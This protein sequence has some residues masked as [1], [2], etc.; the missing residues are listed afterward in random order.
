MKRILTIFLLLGIWL[1]GYTQVEI[2]NDAFDNDNDGLIDLN[3]PDC[4][5][6]ET[7]PSGLIPNPSFEGMLCCPTFEAQ[8][9]CSEDWI[10]AS[11]ATSD[12]F[13]TC[14]TFTYPNWLPTTYQT[15]T[16]LPDGEGW[17]GFRDGNTNR[18]NYKEYVGAKL[19]A[20]MEVG[21]VYKLDFY[22]GFTNNTD[23]RGID[24]TFYG[25][26]SED[27]LPFG[28]GNT[29]IGCPLNTPGWVQIEQQYFEGLNEWI[30]VQVEFEPTQPFNT[31]V[32]GPGCEIH[33]DWVNQPYYFVDRLAL[34]EINEFD[35][36]FE[37]I[38]GNNCDPLI[39]LKAP[40][41][42]IVQYT[43]QWYK[44][45][46]ALVGEEDETLE[47]EVNE[48]AEGTYVVV[49]GVGSSCFYSEDY[50]LELT[51]R[52]TFLKEEICQGEVFEIAGQQLTESVST[53]FTFFSSVGCDS[54]VYVDLTVHEPQ[55][56]DIH[57]TI[58]QGDIYEIEGDILTQ[59][60]VYTYI[61]ES[62]AGCDSTIFVSLTVNESS[63]IVISPNICQGESYVI[64]GNQ[65]TTT[66]TYFY[67][68]LKKNG[69]DSTVT[70][71]LT[72]Y[73]VYQNNITIDICEGEF[74][75]IQNDQLSETGVY[76]Y[77]MSSID[78]CDSLV[79]IDLVV[80]ASSS[81]IDED[82]I[83]AGE[84]FHYLDQE[85]SSAGVYEV[86]TENSV[87]CD[88]VILL[89]LD[90][91][92]QSGSIT[93]PEDINISLGDSVIISPTFVSSELINLEWFVDS[94]VPVRQEGNT[95]I[96]TPVVSTE[97]TLSGEDQYGCSDEDMINIRV[98]RDIGI[99]APN[100]FSPNG[101]SNND[102]WK[103]VANKAISK[104][105]SL[106]VYDRWGNKVYS[107]TDLENPNE[108]AGWDGMI[109]GNPAS[110]GV[111][112]FH[113]V[114]LAKDGKEELKTGDI[115]L[116]R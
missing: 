44:D 91:I 63:D 16:P 5:C 17:V 87:G 75:Q 52:E 57:E 112:V 104:L 113:V 21:K 13:H 3:D 34:A 95:V 6:P 86:I 42:D 85:F 24:L 105:I 48:A 83:C 4:E 77:T 20:T 43:Y 61:L 39:T 64:D 109:N 32:L 33:D 96:L 68:Y 30:Q 25:H 106:N 15:P 100:I 84:V 99:Y 28:Q 110:Q 27:V 58:C 53:S 79:S 78:G 2:C 81:F 60:G 69:C 35:V 59:S 23:F 56:I 46:I 90:V 10:Q 115:T 47:I 103:I 62:F 88:S 65:L 101:D 93:L 73:D 41:G 97:L 11:A 92:S 50:I 45:G 7:V 38:T 55:I 18:P 40:S 102:N 31:F 37:E 26:T 19:N 71:Q 116:L 74:Y 22:L 9:E 89:S 111:Y 72:V 1:H 108:Y 14:G 67:N 36:P 49:F 29:V 8:F 98:K 66:D 80:N 51:E 12:Y 76:D 107:I 70:V 114:Y 82:I 54:I 94:N